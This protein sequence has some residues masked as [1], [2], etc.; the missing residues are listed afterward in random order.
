MDKIKIHSQLFILIFFLQSP[1]LGAVEATDAARTMLAELN[2]QQSVDPAS[3]DRNWKKPERIIMVTGGMTASLD[4]SLRA[5]FNSAADGAELIIVSEIDDAGDKIKGANV[6]LGMCTQ[7]SREMQ[8]LKWVQHY[9]AGVETCIKHRD[10]LAS[11]A[12]LTNMKGVYGPGIAEHVI[13]MMFSLSRGLHQFQRQQM[14]ARWNQGLARDYPMQ[15][16]QGKTLLVVGLGG[17]GLEIAWRANALGMQVVATRNSSREKP[18]YVKYVGL[19]D[20]LFTLAATAD[21]VVNATPLTKSTKGL[22]DSNFFAV[23]KPMAYFINIGRGKSVVTSDLVTALEKGK[24]AGAALDVVDPEPLPGDHVLWSMP[25]VIITPHISAYSDLVMQRFW[26]FVRE[27]L[28]RYV[29]GE[30]LLNV[31]NLDRGY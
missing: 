12:V 24:L 26:V 11:G 31:V 18:G 28:R 20:E 3:K 22:F 5:E 15:E 16:L 4:Q 14:K 2:I 19:A 6:L 21:V 29:Q 9:S 8:Q 13:A 17:I 7:V 27:N 1:I 23:L 25:N 30:R 10:F